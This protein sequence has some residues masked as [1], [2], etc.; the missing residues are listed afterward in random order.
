VAKASPKRRGLG[1]LSL[2]K[3]RKGRKKKYA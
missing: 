1:E 3:K 2:M